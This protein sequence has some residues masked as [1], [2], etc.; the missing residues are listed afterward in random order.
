MGRQGSRDISD[1]VQ[2]VKKIAG[3]GTDGEYRTEFSGFMNLET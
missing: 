2:D 3:G 1:M